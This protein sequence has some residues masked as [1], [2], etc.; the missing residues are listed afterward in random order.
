LTID[1][2]MFYLKARNILF[3]GEGLKG[4]GAFT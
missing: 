2:L 3:K 1:E 4:S